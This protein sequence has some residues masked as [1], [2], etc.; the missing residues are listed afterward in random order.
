MV[1]H[2]PPQTVRESQK[3]PWNWGF[4]TP[5]LKQDH[6][7]SW[8]A[9]KML[10]D[11]ISCSSQFTFIQSCC[12]D[13]KGNGRACKARRCGFESRPQLHLWGQHKGADDPCKIVA[14]GA[15]PAVSTRFPA[16]PS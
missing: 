4:S 13:R 11:P 10:L 6:T 14:A 9:W 15:L 8:G 2:S 3:F 7:P 12:G 16:M 5:K 1:L